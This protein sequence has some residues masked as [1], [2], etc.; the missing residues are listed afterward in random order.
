MSNLKAPFPYF[1]EK[2]SIV[3]IVWQALGKVK[4][5][6]KPFF[7]PHCIYKGIDSKQKKFSFGGKE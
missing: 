7:S 3:G 6:I 5:Y 2:S 1:G 4:H